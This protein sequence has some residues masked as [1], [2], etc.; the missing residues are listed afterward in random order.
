MKL[1]TIITLF[2]TIAIFWDDIL[3]W[4]ERSYREEIAYAV[5]DDTRFDE[6]SNTYGMP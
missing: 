4:R 3:E 5:D 1:L 6:V 2:A